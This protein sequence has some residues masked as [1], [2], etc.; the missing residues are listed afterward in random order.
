MVIDAFAGCC[1]N[2]PMSSTLRHSTRRLELRNAQVL[3]RQGDCWK[4]L[5]QTIND[6]KTKE[7]KNVIELGR[8]TEKD[9]CL[10]LAMDRMYQVRESQPIFLVNGLDVRS[11]TQ[12]NANGTTGGAMQLEQL[13][14]AEM[15]ISSFSIV[16]SQSIT[17]PGVTNLRQS[18]RRPGAPS[19][20]PAL[21]NSFLDQCGSAHAAPEIRLS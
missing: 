16:D 15:A 21:I 8:Q 14:I 17:P 12:S 6:L 2:I 7:L 3:S 18:P 4:M 10:S 1:L 19:S 13:E 9:I 20:A 5:R 11:L